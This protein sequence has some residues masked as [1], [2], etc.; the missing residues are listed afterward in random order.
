M[1]PRAGLGVAALASMLAAGACLASAC[2]EPATEPPEEVTAPAPPRPC[3]LE[4]PRSLAGAPVALAPR[5]LV[6][7]EG[8]A[9]RM[10]WLDQ[11]DA[12]LAIDASRVPRRGLVGHGSGVLAL[13]QRGAEVV[14]L[15]IAAD[16]ASA[17]TVARGELRDG[18]LAAR[19]D[20]AT[21]AWTD[22]SGALRVATVDLLAR[23]ASEPE[24]LGT[25]EGASPLVAMAR[26]ESVVTWTARGASR[27]TLREGRSRRADAPGMPLDLLATS[28]RV[29][30]LYGSS[31]RTGA[32]LSSAG[33]PAVRVTHPEAR[34]ASPTI[35]ALPDGALLAYREDA[36][37]FLQRLTSD[38]IPRGG[39]IVA[40]S[41]GDAP[42]TPPLLATDGARAWIAWEASGESG[43][44]TRVRIADCR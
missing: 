14:L 6:V 10:W 24:T 19:G 23:R 38:A 27:I 44:E 34:P 30:L 42:R 11:A 20:S 35:R 26:A 21:A 15:E 17:I 12:S 18:A 2:D 29:S 25:I 37:L 36:D 13:A 43:P 16:A 32:W 39:P 4:A 28:E 8:D 9:L 1:S 40:G 31:D 3:T 33:A 22:E 5:A 41:S 7:R